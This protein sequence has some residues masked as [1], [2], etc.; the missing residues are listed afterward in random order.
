MLRNRETNFNLKMIDR[1]RFGLCEI[2]SRL[3]ALK[4]LQKLWNLQKRTELLIK[5]YYGKHYEITRIRASEK[6]FS[7][8]GSKPVNLL[9]IE[10]FNVLVNKSICNQPNI[11]FILFQSIRQSFNLNYNSKLERKKIIDQWRF[12]LCGILSLFWKLLS[13]RI[14]DKNEFFIKSYSYQ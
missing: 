12:R 2:L 11:T 7:V 6:K 10:P 8:A 9:G 5:S 4:L 1:W 3:V 13:N 14:F